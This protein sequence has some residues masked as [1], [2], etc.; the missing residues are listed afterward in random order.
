ML[1][2]LQSALRNI[3]LFLLVVFVVPILMCAG[4][5]AAVEWWSGNGTLH[6][7]ASP[8][9]SLSVSIDGAPAEAVYPGQHFTREL[10]QGAHR[11]AISGGMGQSSFDVDVSNGMWQQLAPTSPQQ[12]WVELDV[13]PFYYSPSRSM[14]TIEGRY[15]ASALIS[16]SSGTYYDD[17]VLPRT[18]SE[19][20]HVDLMQPIPCGMMNAPDDQILSTLRFQL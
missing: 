7:Q 18:V 6:I 8:G 12:C 15:P 2:F 14:P 3:R 19:H 10:P 16:V 9:E 4:A 11:V 20:T 17:T 1:Q 5:F 13:Y